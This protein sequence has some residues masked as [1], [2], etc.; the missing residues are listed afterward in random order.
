[1]DIKD[2]NLR[3]SNCFTY[4]IGDEI[5]ITLY[6]TMLFPTQE[7]L[8]YYMMLRAFAKYRHVKRISF[9]T[10]KSNNLNYIPICESLM[11]ATIQISENTVY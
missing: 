7:H 4:L 5:H 8:Y 2:K 11:S 6:F 10:E 3:K 9:K 1:M